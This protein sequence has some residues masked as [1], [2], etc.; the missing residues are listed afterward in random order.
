MADASRLIGH[1]KER[2]YFEARERVLGRCIDGVRPA[3][4]WIA[5]KL[6]IAKQ[7]G[8]AIGLAGADFRS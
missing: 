4:H 1:F 2:A 3:S 5:V 7:Q 6:E 8:I